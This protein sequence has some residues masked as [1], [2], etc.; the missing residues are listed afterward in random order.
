MQL[1]K[2]IN[3]MNNGYFLTYFYDSCL[4]IQCFTDYVYIY[5]ILLKRPKWN[6]NIFFAFSY[7]HI[8]YT[9]SDITIMFPSK[10]INIKFPVFP[11]KYIN[12]NYNNKETILILTHFIVNLHLSFLFPWVRRP[13]LE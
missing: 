3:K 1:N 9:F 8:N 6:L 5:N 12:I 11:S 10:Y 7:K 13:C 4:I 2:Y